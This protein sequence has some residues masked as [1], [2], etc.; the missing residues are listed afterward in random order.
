MTYKY[1]RLG[2]LLNRPVATLPLPAAAERQ[3]RWHS[4]AENE[5]RHHR[6][7]CGR[8]RRIVDCLPRSRSEPAKLWH[9]TF[10]EEGFC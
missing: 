2:V 9:S 8:S 3:Y 4:R 5:Q 10:P 1:L 6:C 7:G